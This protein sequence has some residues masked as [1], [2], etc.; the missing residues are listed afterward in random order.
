[1]SL[2]YAG[3]RFQGGLDYIYIT[4]LAKPIEL[5]NNLFLVFY[6][7]ARHNP[8]M[9]I[10][11]TISHIDDTVK[12]IFRSPVP[13]KAL[14]DP[15]AVPHWRAEFVPLGNI[16]FYLEF[17]AGPLE[18]RDLP[19]D[20]IKAKEL[21]LDDNLIDEVLAKFITRCEALIKELNLAIDTMDRNLIFKVAHTI[22]GSSRN[23]FAIQIA[24]EALKI[25][26]I[27]QTASKSELEDSYH[28]LR[29]RF[30]DFLQYL[31]YKT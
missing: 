15:E 19:F 25:E 13:L 18:V 3:Y 26:K 12:W 28:Q 27:Y 31:E 5:K 2:G 17:P 1:M 9:N 8:E 30:D 23:V 20:R 7:L 14:D 22:K 10:F 16:G 4:V 21:Y 11:F 29:E 24:S 6:D